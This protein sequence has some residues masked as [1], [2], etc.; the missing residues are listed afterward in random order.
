MA[1]PP[2]RL[3]VQAGSARADTYSPASDALVTDQVEQG[4]YFCCVAIPAIS[5]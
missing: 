4:R 5:D 3:S 2:L 1:R